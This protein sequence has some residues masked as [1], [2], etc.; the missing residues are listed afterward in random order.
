MSP[1]LKVRRVHT[2]SAYLRKGVVRYRERRDKKKKHVRAEEA[3]R[4][5]VH[6]EEKG[7]RMVIVVTQK[8]AT[9]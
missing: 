8:D 5:D 6:G 3:V 4:K 1:S 7:E 9:Q 2:R